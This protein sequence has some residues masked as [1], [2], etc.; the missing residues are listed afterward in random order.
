MRATMH[1][2]FGTVVISRFYWSLNT[3]Q[4]AGMGAGPM[5]YNV[6]HYLLFEKGSKNITTTSLPSY[7]STSSLD[8]LRE[9]HVAKRGLPKTKGVPIHT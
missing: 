8:V 3:Y 7:P 9:P 6:K 2:L 4:T 1:S 5:A